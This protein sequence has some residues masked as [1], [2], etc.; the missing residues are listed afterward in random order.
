VTD[1]S[2]ARQQAIK[3]IKDKRGFQQHLLTYLL[4]NAFLWVIWAVTGADFPWPIFITLGWGIGVVS[5]WWAVYGRGGRPITEDEI[6]REM[7][8][9]QDG[10]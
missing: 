5:N 7:G 4:V 2:E 9:G 6:R 8:Q 3:R 1:E 10:A